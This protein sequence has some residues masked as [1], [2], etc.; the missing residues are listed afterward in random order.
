MANLIR[1]KG[2]KRFWWYVAETSFKTTAEDNAADRSFVV[3]FNWLR[4]SR[5]ITLGTSKG[6]RSWIKRK[7]F[8]KFFAG[9]T[10]R[11]KLIDF[12]TGEVEDSKDVVLK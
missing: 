4:G 5:E 1:T 2:Y 7:T 6:G 9:Q 10:I 8:S 3:T 11:V 12:E